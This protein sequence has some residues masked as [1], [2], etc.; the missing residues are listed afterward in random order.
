MDTLLS[1]PGQQHATFT[2]SIIET[3]RSTARSD[4]GSVPTTATSTW[5]P[6]TKSARPRRACPTTWA[7]VMR[8][9]SPVTTADPLPRPVR[10]AAT[11]PVSSAATALTVR[12]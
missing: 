12:E 5:A 1:R 9:P 4:S 10:T 2:E 3:A 11:L 6:S 8:I 7:F